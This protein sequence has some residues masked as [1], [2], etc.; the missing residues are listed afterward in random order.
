MNLDVDIQGS[1]DLYFRIQAIQGNLSDQIRNAMG[2]AAI[3]AYRHMRDNIPQSRQNKR[4]GDY[5]NE[6]EPRLIDDLSIT[7]VTYLPGGA[8]GGG[9][10]EMQVGWPGGAPEHLKWVM[11][12]TSNWWQPTAMTIRTNPGN[13]KFKN[14]GQGFFSHHR[15][16]QRANDRWWLEAKQLADRVIDSEFSRLDLSGLAPGLRRTTRMGP[17]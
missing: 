7:K 6:G 12:G 5:K 15:K 10:Y 14:G 4:W 13:I 17:A 2:K 8:G 9:T 16:G 3:V 11:D 1:D